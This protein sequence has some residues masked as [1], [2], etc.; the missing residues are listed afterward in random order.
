[1]NNKIRYKIDR[2]N[3]ITFKKVEQPQK[4]VHFNPIQKYTTYY[5]VKA[6]P[7]SD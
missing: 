2:Q 1:M 4:Q 3:K 6:S 7:K 5:D